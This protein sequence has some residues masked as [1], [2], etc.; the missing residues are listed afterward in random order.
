MRYI[1]ISCTWGKLIELLLWHRMG[2]PYPNVNVASV[3]RTSFHK[4]KTDM[5]TCTVHNIMEE[6]EGNKEAG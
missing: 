2:A 4:M 3:M 5:V 6:A 1:K